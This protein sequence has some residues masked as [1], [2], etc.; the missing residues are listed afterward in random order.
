MC[1]LKQVYPFCL[2]R[3]YRFLLPPAPIFEK[4]EQIVGDYPQI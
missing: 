1:R 2:S 3:N 4:I